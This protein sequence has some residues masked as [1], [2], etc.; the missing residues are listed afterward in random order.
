MSCGTP[1]CT[2]PPGAGSPTTSTTSASVQCYNCITR[3]SIVN[4]V[5]DAGRPVLSDSVNQY[6]NLPQDDDDDTFV[7]D[8]TGNNDRLGNRVKIWVEQAYHTPIT[9]EFRVAPTPR[10]FV[11]TDDERGANSSYVYSPSAWASASGGNYNSTFRNYGTERHVQIPAVG[12]KEYTVEVRCGTCGNI[13]TCGPITALRRVWYFVAAMEQ[14]EERADGTVIRTP[15]SVPNLTSFKN[16]YLNNFG[17]V[18]RELPR[19]TISEFVYRGGD[20]DEGHIRQAI[21]APFRRSGGRG[22]PGHAMAFVF[23]DQIATKTPHV[24]RD[25]VTL[26]RGS[27]LTIPLSE[28]L[29]WGM[30]GPGGEWFVSA[31]FYPTGYGNVALSQSMFTPVLGSSVRNRINQLRLRVDEVFALIERDRNPSDPPVGSSVSGMI[32]ITLNVATE[33]CGGYTYSGYDYI[34]MATRANWEDKVVGNIIQVMK[35]EFGHSLKMVPT[36]NRTRCYGLD[37]GETWYEECGHQGPHCHH[38]VNTVLPA[39]GEY[40]WAHFMEARC[41]MYGSSGESNYRNI[42]NYCDS[43][44]N[45]VKKV[46]MS[47]GW[48]S[49]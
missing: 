22:K 30:G 33:W 27:D 13:V 16:Y 37:P 29:W 8:V 39:S 46:D 26:T 6:V 23:I 20:S 14:A 15:V 17:I 40:G 25:N 4:G 42:M 18:M 48:T 2:N 5:N 21:R 31:V 9:F 10:E 24:E 43:C 7:D 1:G 45:S 19:Q 34:V 44:A 3:V 11:Y 35:H 47:R 49:S 36:D 28:S 41:N 12:N 38:G 32:T